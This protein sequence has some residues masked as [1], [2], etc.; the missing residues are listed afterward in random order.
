M[1]MTR[2]QCRRYDP[3]GEDFPKGHYSNRIVEH[4][5]YNQGMFWNV[6]EGITLV[7][8]VGGAVAVALGADL[9][10]VSLPIVL[11]LLS[12]AVGRR[13]ERVRVEVRMINLVSCEYKWM[14]VRG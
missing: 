8:G 3:G 1:R 2:I 11:P 6:L 5:R 12:L 13:R 7:G 10:L 4:E 14:C 9:V